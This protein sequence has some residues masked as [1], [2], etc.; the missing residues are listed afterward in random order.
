[1]GVFIIFLIICIAGYFFLT[2]F[3]SLNN[4]NKKDETGHH[5]GVVIITGIILLAIIGGLLFAGKS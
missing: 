1:M 3:G 5:A 4:P 2:S